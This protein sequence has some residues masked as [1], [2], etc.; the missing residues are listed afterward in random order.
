MQTRL[1]RLV[2]G[3]TA[4]SQPIHSDPISLPRA[5]RNGVGPPKKTPFSPRRKFAGNSGQS[6]EGFPFYARLSRLA[7]TEL[8]AGMPRA[9]SPDF[10]EPFAELA[11]KSL[12]LPLGAFSR[13]QEGSESSFSLAA[14][15]RFFWSFPK[16]NGVESYKPKACSHANMPKGAFI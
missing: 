11:H 8:E 4:V 14:R 2:C 10:P 7:C 6:S 16:R 9:Q 3:V 5:A 12:R 15:H 1:R 13:T